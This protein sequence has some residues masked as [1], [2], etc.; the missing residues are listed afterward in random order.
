MNLRHQMMAGAVA[1]F[2]AV[3]AHAQDKLSKDDQKFIKDAGAGNAT[4][5]EM[6]KLAQQNGASDGVKQFGQRLA[7][8]H[9]KANEE[10]RQIADRHGVSFAAAPHQKDI[11]KFSRLKG[12]Q[13]DK[14]FAGHMVKDHKLDIAKF[15]T[16]A[17]KGKSADVKTFAS[18]A[19]PTLEEHLKI[20]QGLTGSGK[21]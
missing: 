15:R 16:E 3:G 9:G 20:A 7:A 2:V 11:D 5:V 10:L 4:E 1:L 14:A 19:L 12:A 21:K 17:K 6:G 8:D 18:D 13:F